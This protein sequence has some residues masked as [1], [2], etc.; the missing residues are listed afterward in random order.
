MKLATMDIGSGTVRLLS[1]EVEGGQFHRLGVK[2]RIT[3]LADGFAGKRITPESMRRTVEAA[4]DFAREARSFGAVE[5]RAACTGVTR[6]AAN[7][8]DFLAALREQA[9]LTPCVITGELEA[10]ISAHGAALE[11]GFT[12]RPFMLLDIGGFSTEVALVREGRIAAA[13][14]L[15]LGAVMLAQQHLGDDPPTPAQLAAC[16]AQ[17]RMTMR[18]KLK[19]MSEAAAGASLVGTAGTVTNLLAMDLK[20]ER[21]EPE[22]INR[23][24][25][26]AGAVMRL[27]ALMVSMPTAERLAIPG[28]EKGREDLLP[29]GA[30]ICREAMD[31][32]GVQRML[33]TEG[34]VLEGLALLPVWPPPAGVLLTL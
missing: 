24:V 3:R 33:V 9:G 19:K 4:H 23:G 2:R 22:R 7:A 27:L 5:I 13:V 14:S 20:M 17:V 31:F 6:R 26:A 15:E 28:L 10:D 29:A 1:A 8:G 34:G 21:Y 18:K 12:D 11:L 16:E 32:L 25:L 30:I